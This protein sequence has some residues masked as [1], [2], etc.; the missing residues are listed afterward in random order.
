MTQP[1]LLTFFRPPFTLLRLQVPF[2]LAG[3]DV[4]SRVDGDDVIPGVGAPLFFEVLNEN[5]YLARLAASLVVS[6][7]LNRTY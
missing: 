4:A 2:T 6:A 5:R 7:V 1:S 3:A